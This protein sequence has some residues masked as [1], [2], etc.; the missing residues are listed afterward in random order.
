MSSDSSSSFSGNL[1]LSKVFD[2]I[3][4]SYFTGDYEA[5]LI[6]G[7]VDGEAPRIAGNVDGEAPLISGNVD[8]EAPR[9]AGNVDGDSTF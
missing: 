4:I 2:L 8:G 3:S 7:N 6:A 9:I 1:F 5:P